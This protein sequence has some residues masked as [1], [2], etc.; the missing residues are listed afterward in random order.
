MKKILSF[1][2]VILPWKLRRCLLVKIYKYE[3]HPTAHIGL[4]YIY[5][6]YLIMKE[7]SKIGHF[8]VAIHLDKVEIGANSSIGRSNWI[9]GFP[10]GTN[11]KHFSHQTDRKSELLIGC[12]SAVTKNHHLDCT[13][14][15]SIGDFCAI[16]GYQTYFLTHS[17]DLYEGRQ[18]SKP[19]KIGN[20]CRI[21]TRSTLLGGSEMPNYSILGACSLLN[22]KYTDEWKLYAG[23]PAKPI[24]DIPKDAKWFH[25]ES[26]F[27]Y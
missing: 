20:Y 4:S 11:S 9:T 25:R 13:S 23:I 3:I 18:D 16:G 24:K 19:I 14:E 5:P 21:S 15:I 22:K 1:I 12:H 6:K 7:N 2:I 26:G 27:V 10:T 8:T 17:T